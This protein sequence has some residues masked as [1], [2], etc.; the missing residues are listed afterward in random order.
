M[1]TNQKKASAFDPYCKDQGIDYVLAAGKA[2]QGCIAFTVT[3]GGT[4]DA[5]LF[6]SYGYD[7]EMADTDYQVLVNGETAAAVSVDESTKTAKGFSII[8]GGEAEKLHVIVLGRFSPMP[9]A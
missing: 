9:A 8:G 4:P 3:S 5:V 7:V 6:S 2:S 1:S